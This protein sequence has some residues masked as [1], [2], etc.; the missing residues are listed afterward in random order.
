MALNKSPGTDGFQI[1]FYIVFWN[2]IQEKIMEAYQYA[3]SIKCLHESARFG[4]ISLIPKKDRDLNYVKNWRP[5]V[6]LNTDYKMLSKVFA[7][8][9]KGVLQKLSTM[10]RQV[11]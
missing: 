1:N 3:I 5:I 4:V 6:F 8:R 9:I 11:F 2:R 7:T 10:I